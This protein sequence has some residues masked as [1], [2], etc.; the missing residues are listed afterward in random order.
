MA[1]FAGK[2]GYSD[3]V[4]IRPGVWVD[5]ITEREYRGDV[6]R[7][8]RSLDGAADKLND[9]LSINNSFSVVA[10]PYAYQNFHTIRYIWWMGQR[11]KVRTVEVQRPRLLLTIG[12]VYNGPTA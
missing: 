6:L 8:S 2:I 7:D 1:R 5:H 3:T 9:D 4:Q 11:W 10:D 12:G